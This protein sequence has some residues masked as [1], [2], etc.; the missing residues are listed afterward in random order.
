MT[1]TSPFD[2][3]TVR[4]TNYRVALAGAILGTVGATLVWVVWLS[5]RSTNREAAVTILIAAFIGLAV[6]WIQHYVHIARQENRGEAPAHNDTPGRQTVLA[7]AWATGFGF[8]GFLTEDLVAHTASLFLRPFLASLTSFVPAAAILAW[9]IGRGRN[10]DDNLLLLIANGL[11][12][13][14]LITVATGI[15]WTVGFGHAPWIALFSWWG[16]FGVAVQFVTGPER[17][18]GRPTDPVAALVI[19]FVAIYLINLL[20]AAVA[21]Y[22]KLGPFSNIALIVREMAA[23]VKQS[24]AVPATFWLEAERRLAIEDSPDTA[25]AVVPAAAPAAAA[26][27]TAILHPTVP[28]LGRA[29]RYLTGPDTVTVPS[30]AV[31]WGTGSHAEFIRS[32]VMLLLFAIGIGLAP[33]V[34]RSL[35]P[36]DYPNS[37]TYRRD[38]TLS[39]A[40]VLFVV[41][42]CLVGRREVPACLGS[43]TNSGRLD[44]RLATILTEPGDSA[45]RRIA[46][47][48]G[49]APQELALV[50]AGPACQRIQ[51]AIDSAA[52]T[53]DSVRLFY[54]FKAGN[55]RYLAQEPEHPPGRISSLLLFDD[56]LKYL[57]RLPAR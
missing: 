13:G 12:S 14:A 32:W 35:R 56:S 19:V 31:P 5:L 49:I 28:D 48:N 45:I 39:V 25:T 22:R 55:A 47:L 26:T 50:T 7:L 11:W 36:L 17:N 20:P 3:A 18:A 6:H 29:V 10:K 16:L 41:A 33:I 38:L 2:A 9:T 27:D 54:L 52:E 24:P 43:D 4:Y 34:E 44:A 51:A 30:R 15:I 1:S 23:D 46:A 40:I 21:P 57:G 42:A 37:E 53:P 8:L